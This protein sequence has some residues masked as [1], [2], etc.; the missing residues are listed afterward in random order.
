MGSETPTGYRGRTPPE[1]EY[2]FALS[3]PEESKSES[4]SANLSQNLF[5]AK[6]RISSDVWGATPWI[7]DDIDRSTS[8]MLHSTVTS[9]T[10]C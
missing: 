5:F 8:S 10:I 9:Q 2:F 6:Q 3:R 4:D 1:A 7:A